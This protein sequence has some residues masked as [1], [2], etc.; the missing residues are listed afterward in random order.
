MTQSS[1]ALVGF[2]GNLLL[3]PIVSFYLMRDW[4]VLMRKLRSLLPRRRRSWSCA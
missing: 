4:D 2:I 3:V 1:L